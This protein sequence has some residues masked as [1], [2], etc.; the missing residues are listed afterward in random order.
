MNWAG[1]LVCHSVGGPAVDARTRRLN[2]SQRM[3]SFQMWSLK[4]AGYRVVS[5][6]EILEFAGGT[7]KRGR[8]ACLTF[9]DGYMDFYD[10]AFPV[11][12]KYGYPSTVFMVS[13]LAGRVNLWDSAK[14]KNGYGKRPLLDWQKAKELS[15]GGVTFGAHTMT[16]PHLTRI[17]AARMKDEILDSKLEIEDRTGSPVDFFCYP[18]GD[19][20][21]DV[22]REVREAG[23]LGATS[24]KRGF[25]LRGDDF[26]KLKRMG[27]GPMTWLSSI[28]MP[29]INT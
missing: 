27:P 5:L 13:G 7:E 11:L 6:K 15:A 17:P 21:K 9:D 4:A 8:F 10:N 24:S 23:F 18:Y 3:F 22:M 16:H 28:C 26:F 14:Y 19:Y 29:A 25:V 2:V 1:I 20:N 12:K